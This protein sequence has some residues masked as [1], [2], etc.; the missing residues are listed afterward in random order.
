MR[1]TDRNVELRLE[2]N[3]DS[4]S[5][6]VRIYIEYKVNQLAN[7][8]KYNEDVRK[9]VLEYLCDK[10]D[11]T[12]LWVALVCQELRRPTVQKRHTLRALT[13]FPAGLTPLYQRMMERILDSEDTAVYHQIL[14]ILCVAYRPMT[15]PELTSVADRLAEY[16]DEPETLE[17]IIDS[18][19]SFLSLQNG[20][21]YFVYQ[22]AK[23]FLLPD[24]P[25]EISQILLHGL[26]HQ[27]RIIF[28]TALKVLSRTLTKPDIYDLKEPGSPIEEITC[29]DPDPLAPVKYALIYWADHLRDSGY[30]DDEVS[31][32][33]YRFFREKFLWWL[34][35][36]SLLRSLPSV[37]L[38]IKSLG[39]FM[40]CST[41]STD[42]V[43]NDSNRVNTML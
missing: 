29:P 25:D 1:A 37:M 23:D 27:H 18:C 40:V 4:I 17:D 13:K 16:K 30:I 19:G 42:P 31:E 34:E 8:K 3:D 41:Q 21:V 9:Q 24:G 20:V 32:A 12:F 11:K 26:R 5:T 39:Q 33:V 2:L 14:G 35:A 7:I 38:A 22:S 43:C 36:M 28:S 10:A 6:A 15:L